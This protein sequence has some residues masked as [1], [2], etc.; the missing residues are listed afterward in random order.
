VAYVFSP[1]SL[2]KCE[3]G[4]WSQI[5]CTAAKAGSVAYSSTT[6]LLV[7]C[8][9]NTW[10]AVNLPPGPQG[11]AGPPGPAGPQGEAGPQGPAGP[12]G[13]QGD[14]GPPGATTLV[15]LTPFSGAAGPC[16]DGGTRIDAG[17]DLNGD[18]ILEPSEIT[19]TAYVCNGAAGSPGSAGEAGAP[20]LQGEAGAPGATSLISLTPAPA[21]ACPYGGTEVQVGVDK[22]GDGVLEPGEVQETSF[23]CNGSSTPPCTPGAKQCAGNTVQTCG[24][25]GQWASGA[26]CGGATPAC[27]DGACVACA[28]ASV[29]CSAEQ[30][31]TCNA[32]GAWQSIGPSCDALQI[33]GAAGSCCSGACVQKNDDPNHCGGCGI[34]CPTTDP[35]AASDSCNAALC[36]LA[37][38]AGFAACNKACASTSQTCVPFLSFANPVEYGGTGPSTGVLIRDFSGDGQPD[39]VVS[40]GTGNSGSIEFLQGNGDGTFH[41]PLYSPFDYPY[42]LDP[43][44]YGY[45]AAADFN[46]DGLPDLAYADTDFSPQGPGV[47]VLLQL[48]GVH[49]AFD[50]AEKNTGA[51]P[52]G[53]AGAA[54]HVATADFN[55][56]G[57]AD[58]AVANTRGTVLSNTLSNVGI[59]LGR[60][61]GTFLPYVDYT[62][63]TASFSVVTGDFNG[64][65]APDL[66]VANQGSNDVSVLLGNGDGTF[67]PAVNYAVGPDP[68]GMALGD[69]NGDGRA[70]LAVANDN[71]NTGQGSLSILLGNG[72]GTFQDAIGVPTDTYPTELAVADFDGDGKEDIAVDTA[73]PA[74]N[75]NATVDVLLGNGDGSFQ[76]FA[77]FAIP[78]QGSFPVTFGIA[79][80]DL[81]GDGRPDIVVSDDTNG[82]AIVFLNTSGLCAEVTGVS[83][84]PSSAEVGGAINLQAHGVDVSGSS[85]NVDFSWAITGGTY[86]GT[87]SSAT[88]ASPTFTCTTPGPVTVTVAASAVNGGGASCTNNTASVQLT[89]LATAG[90]PDDLSNIGTGDFHISFTVTTTQGVEASILNQRSGCFHGMFWDLSL[91]AD[92]VLQMETDDSASGADY[93]VLTTAATVNDGNPH[94][95]IVERVSGM[96][97]VSVG[98]VSTAAAA[99]TA[100][101][102]ALVPLRQGTDVCTGDAPFAGSISNVCVTSP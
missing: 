1:P 78:G 5:A 21:S 73:G 95:V 56:D 46:G 27:L 93:T 89:C 51:D 91:L 6:M 53:P 66:A 101:F 30:P 85:S 2:W 17:V 13:P 62:T 74:T 34:Q 72:D 50:I 61:D 84:S 23:V 38:K 44:S 54:I 24:A 41:A 29:R 31:Q 9:N 87:L 32:A 68:W 45:L 71:G 86:S 11:D 8:I 20:G 63:H 80:G 69:F 58:L 102:G 47:T 37:C 28:P 77:E 67:Q 88:G 49:G 55:R 36:V 70:D 60:G 39:I 99:S 57:I 81:N 18:G 40:G 42:E 83:A 25:N 22:N 16:M 59:L 7:A 26:A 76:P 10:T 4:A 48:L 15:T 19:T 35:N 33:S 52:T 79:A 94:Q 100:N 82:G 98:S 65:G 90:C 64:D 14:A 92:G 12:S 43:S 3:A 96:L 75:Y 97:T